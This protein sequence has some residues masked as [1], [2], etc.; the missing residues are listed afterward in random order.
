MKPSALAGELPAATGVCSYFSFDAAKD[1]TLARVQMHPGDGEALD[2]GK[3][4]VVYGIVGVLELFACTSLFLY[5][6][7]RAGS[8]AT[9]AI[10]SYLLMITARTEVGSETSILAALRAGRDD[11]GAQC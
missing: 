5:R 10:G 1:P 6:R 7:G 4:V 3:S 8:P 2:W 11:D 9:C